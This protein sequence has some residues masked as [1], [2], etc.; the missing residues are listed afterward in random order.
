MI[1]LNSYI[2]SDD[3][4]AQYVSLEGDNRQL[5]FLAETRI[6]E[7]A[8][9][10]L[11]CDESTFVEFPGSPNIIIEFSQDTPLTGGYVQ[12]YFDKEKNVPVGL[13]LRGT[14][15]GRL[16]VPGER[17]TIHVHYPRT[18]NTPNEWGF[19]CYVTAL[20]AAN[21]ATTTAVQ[22]VVKTE[23][24]AN[25][26]LKTLCQMS[27]HIIFTL[28]RPMSDMM[29]EVE[30]VLAGPVLR[31]GLLPPISVSALPPFLDYLIHHSNAPADIVSRANQFIKSLRTIFFGTFSICCSLARIEF[32]LKICNF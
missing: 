27:G 14:L 32:L 30:D 20:P 16:V 31:K 18:A 24:V 17:V 22:D 21:D 12:L 4:F 2:K 11:P 9:P 5:P 15:P 26:L 10:I 29:P 13:P 6:V 7:S 19:R 25:N 23:P 8:H 3:A 28:L 1:E